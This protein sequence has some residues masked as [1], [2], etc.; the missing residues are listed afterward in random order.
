MMVIVEKDERTASRTSTVPN[1]LL[2]T[3]E[4]Y[5]DVKLNDVLTEE[6]KR[7]VDKLL[8]VFTSTLADK[9]GLTDLTEVSMKLMDV[10]RTMLAAPR[11]S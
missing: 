9:P 6:Q 8:Q 10:I 1:C 11:Q 4:N 3:S 7:G 5:R 2:K